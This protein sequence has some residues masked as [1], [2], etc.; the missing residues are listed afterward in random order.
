MFGM[1]FVV[2]VV[3]ELD[4]LCEAFYFV[5]WFFDDFMPLVGIIV[6]WMWW[7][8]DVSGMVLLIAG[9]VEVVVETLVMK[10]KVKL[11]VFVEVVLWVHV[12]I[13]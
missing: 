5:D 8:I 3:S 13:V 9:V 11:M 12:E 4:V 7:V 10:L 6:N 1:V 2:V